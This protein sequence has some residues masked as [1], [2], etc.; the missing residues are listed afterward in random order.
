[1]DGEDDDGPVTSQLTPLQ[2]D[3]VSPPKDKRNTLTGKNVADSVYLD[4]LDNI[5]DFWDVPDPKAIHIIVELPRGKRWV[6][7]VS[8]ILLTALF[9]VY[10]FTTLYIILRLCSC[11]SPRHL[12][13]LLSYAPNPF[14][15][16]SLNH[17]FLPFPVVGLHVSALWLVVPPL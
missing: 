9:S 15:V 3:L 8:E 7:W 16:S 4:E 2:V 17:S 11:S 13:C 6:Q 14:H 10:H 1:M 5:S 12:P